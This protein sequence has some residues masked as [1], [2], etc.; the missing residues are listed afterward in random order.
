[1]RKLNFVFIRNMM[2]IFSIILLILLIFQIH[3]TEKRVGKNSNQ[4]VPTEISI[5]FD[6][7]EFFY[8]GTGVLNLMEGVHASNQDGE[9]LT[10]EVHAVITADGT[11]QR[12]IICYSI[13]QE[14]RQIERL[15]TLI[16]RNYEGP[17]LS[18]ASP[19]FF[20]AADLDNLI[21][22]LKERGGLSANDGYG[23]D[24]TDRVTCV[25]KKTNGEEYQMTFQ[26]IN[27]YQDMT[28]VNVTAYITGDV[29]D[30]AIRLVSREATV[31][32]GTYFDPA[33]YIVSAHDGIN[34]VYLDSIAI[35]SNVDTQKPGIY[36]VVY[37]LYNP[38][39]TA[40]TVEVLQVMV[41]END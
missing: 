19:L 2:G 8:D 3:Q 9:D 39:K 26:V 5:E 37:R 10:E 25:R 34:D 24:I 35:Q 32:Q 21:T 22:L 11:L 7:N 1:M 16:M 41:Q 33:N 12:K 40:Y 27:D 15:R 28:E 17:Y 13:I 18:V 31:A 6:S 4:I 30:P 38:E 23:K 20:D 14:H 29:P 36:R